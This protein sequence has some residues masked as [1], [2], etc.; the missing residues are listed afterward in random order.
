M[1][2]CLYKCGTLVFYFPVLLM[3]FSPAFSL[4]P[5]IQILKSF[6]AADR[7]SLVVTNSAYGKYHVMLV[8]CHETQTQA[9]TERRDLLRGSLS[10]S[11]KKRRPYCVGADCRVPCYMVVKQVGLL[12][13]R[14]KLKNQ[15]VVVSSQLNCTPSST[16]KA[17]AD[18]SGIQSRSRRL[19]NYWFG[20]HGIALKWFK[21]FSS[22]RS[23][24][25]KCDKNVSSLYTSLCGVP[26]ALF[27]VLY[28]LSSILPL[29]VPLFHLSI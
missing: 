12:N 27:S 7:M 16:E 26:Q 10:L 24:R 22:S 17:C 8:S 28:F 13:E 14:M 6:S 5:K 11:L 21:S 29:L 18:S 9:F 3:R 2:G 4:D 19:E 23:F 25:V 20:I 15:K 1:Q